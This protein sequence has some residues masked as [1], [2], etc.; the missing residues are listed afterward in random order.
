MLIRL[1]KP[2]ESA[3]ITATAT[4]VMSAVIGAALK[5][6][7]AA[8]ARLNPIIMTIEPVT[9]GGSSQL[10]HPIPTAFTMRPTTASMTPVANTP[11]SAT[12]KPPLA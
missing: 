3:P 12:A 7:F 1:K 10:I 6:L 8:P 2:L 5:L 9:S 4:S 11:P